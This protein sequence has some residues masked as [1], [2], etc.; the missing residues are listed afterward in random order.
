MIDSGD[1]GD[2]GFG[3]KDVLDSAQID[4][5]WKPDPDPRV[6]P[7]CLPPGRA[8][9]GRDYE[10]I[11]DEMAE[12]QRERAESALLET[13]TGGLW[14]NDYRGV[15]NPIARSPVFTARSNRG[16]RRQ[17]DKTK[18]DSHSG[19]EIFASGEELDQGDLDVFLGLLHVTRG[20]LLKDRCVLKVSVFL[21]KVLGKTDTGK[22]RALL[23]A[24]LNRLEDF[25][26]KITFG[27]KGYYVGELLHDFK[28]L[29]AGTE[30]DPFRG[31]EIFLNPRL[32]GFFEPG[33]YSL[34]HWEIRK[35]LRHR[36]IAQWLHCFYSSHLESVHTYGLDRL[37]TMAGLTTKSVTKRRQLV[38][39]GLGELKS[40]AR[41]QGVEM[42]FEV[43]A[44]RLVRVRGL[45][46]AQGLP[47]VRSLP[48][49]DIFDIGA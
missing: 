1:G 41:I 37:A 38:R 27:K 30:T 29:G 35:S 2:G 6:G 36:P 34:I 39:V 47:R 9:T 15:P 13:A 20:Q 8:M 25:K 24:S 11:A 3:P 43:D 32:A 19:Y 28:A 5:G 31:Y 7:L 18:L 17:F 33:H 23:D 40:A 16:P 4:F 49:A 22:N 26:L 12:R 42:N 14:P 21:K 46:E 45:R 44:K 10:R 48:G